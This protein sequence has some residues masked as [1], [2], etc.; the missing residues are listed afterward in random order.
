MLTAFRHASA[1]ICLLLLA[2]AAQAAE[3]LSAIKNL[4]QPSASHYAAGQPSPEQFQ[5]LQQAGIQHIINFRP[6]Q[7]QGD[8]DEAKLV[9]NLG[10][11]YHNLPIASGKDFTPEAIE[12]FDR[13]LNSIGDEK[14]LLH[15]AS[16]NRVGAMMA[17]RANWLQGASSEQALT[18][19]KSYGLTRLEAVI[20]PLMK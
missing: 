16:S 10:M 4:R 20:T 14:V 3:D 12:Q 19:G 11:Q 8:F 7:E 18:V 2:L 15:C 6:Q 1:L 13:L 5:Q 17:L 9:N